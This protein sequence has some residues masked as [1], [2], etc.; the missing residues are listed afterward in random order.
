M[1]IKQIRNYVLLVLLGIIFGG[2]SKDKK[3]NPII[4]GE[5]NLVWGFKWDS[6]QYSYLKSIDL[7][8]GYTINNIKLDKINS[9]S[10]NLIYNKNNN[11]FL[12]TYGDSLLSFSVSNNKLST[13]MFIGHNIYGLKLNSNEQLLYGFQQIDSTINLIKVNIIQKTIEVI[14][15]QFKG[16]PNY[17]CT[18]MDLSGE[19]FYF[20]TLDSLYYFNLSEKILKKAI[21]IKANDLEY[22]SNTNELNYIGFVNCKFKLSK[23]DLDLVNIRNLDFSTEIEAFSGLSTFNTKTGDYVFKGNGSFL[24]IVDQNGNIKTL[25]CDIDGSMEFQNN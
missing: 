4:I 17:F 19:K 5:T 22:N 10:T 9:G 25:N 2:C 7:N 11:E 14:N 8:S 24:H 16:D 13:I 21:K 18:A 15:S 20:S 12:F 1:N 6:Y 23:I 3:N